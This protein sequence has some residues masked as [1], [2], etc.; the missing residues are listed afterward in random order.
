[1]KKALKAAV[2]GLFLT[3]TPWVGAASAADSAPVKIGFVTTLTTPA[4]VIGTDMKNGFDLA[5]EHIGREMGGRKGGMSPGHGRGRRRWQSWAW[6]SAVAEA[7]RPSGPA[8][9]S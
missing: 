6:F 5:L 1:M 2:F 9:A 4:A 3:A 8:W 7:P